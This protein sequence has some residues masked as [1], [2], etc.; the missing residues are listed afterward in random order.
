[1]CLMLDMPANGTIQYIDSPAGPFGYQ[2]KA[3]Y[4]C[5]DGFRLSNC[6]DPVL[7]CVGGY[8]TSGQGWLGVPPSCEC[9]SNIL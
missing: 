8:G 3:S 4:T 2:A 1:M 9:T 5:D 6:G 7:T